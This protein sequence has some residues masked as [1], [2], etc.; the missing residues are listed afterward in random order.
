MVFKKFENKLILR[1]F[2]LLITLSLPAIVWVNNMPELLIFLAPLLF[3]QVAELIRFQKQTQED[4][5]LFVESV[6]YRDFSRFFNEQNAT[7]EVKKLRQGFNQ[8]NSAFKNIN[9]EKEIQHQHL[10]KILELVN[11]GIITYNLQ[12]GEVLL[13]NEAL[14]KLLHVP[15]MNNITTLAKRETEFFA[16]VQ[17]LPPGQVKIATIQQGILEQNPIKVLLAATVFQSEGQSYKLVALQNV[18]EALDETES[19]AWEKLLNVL[20][21]EIMNSVAPISSLANTLKTR[22]QEREAN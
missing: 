22:L 9:R 5:N 10:Q 13:M 2:L 14:K 12:T 18:N 17:N 6:H 4:L 20:T 16:E 7:E 19:K 1:V 8:I 21:H 11:T 3:F 15:F